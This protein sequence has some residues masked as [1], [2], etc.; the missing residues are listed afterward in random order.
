MPRGLGDDHFHF[1]SL[2]SMQ[3][4]HESRGLASHGQ[5]LDHSGATAELQLRMPS[6]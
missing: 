4:A 2:C 3:T 1:M 5:L 6:W